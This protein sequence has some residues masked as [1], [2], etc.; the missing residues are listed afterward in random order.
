M[1]VDFPYVHIIYTHL[2]MSSHTDTGTRKHK[3]TDSQ[4]ICWQYAVGKN[5]FLPVTVTAIQGKA[6]GS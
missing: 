3:D 6:I 2:H 4:Y 5:S 1:S